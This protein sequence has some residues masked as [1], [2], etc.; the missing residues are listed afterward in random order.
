MPLVRPFIA[1][2]AALLAVLAALLACTAQMWR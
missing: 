1:S 2:V